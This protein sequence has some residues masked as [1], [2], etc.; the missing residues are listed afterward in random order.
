MGDGYMGWCDLNG[1]K[2]KE[3]KRKKEV[4]VLDE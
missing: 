1:E 4:V 2:K 3:R